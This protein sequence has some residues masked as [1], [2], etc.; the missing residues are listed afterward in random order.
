MQHEELK[1]ILEA[2]L[3]SSEKPISLATLTALF[4]EKGDITPQEIRQA[5]HS[6]AQDYRHRAFELKEVASG[7]CLQTKVQYAAW[8]G[9]LQQE[10]PTKYSRA[11]LE[12]LAIIAYQ[13]PVTRADIE[14]IRGV[15]VSSNL[16]KTLLER[17]WI[18][19][20]GHRD[21]PGKPLLYWTTPVFLNYF[22]L[23]KLT[24]LPPL[25]ACKIPFE[26]LN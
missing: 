1:L 17:G 14:N 15:S 8:I 13:Q 2:L 5:L 22:N 12:T 10:K 11:L 3:V 24:D 18:K 20:A 21:V 9:Q 16:L 19:S 4:D 26:D 6:L 25:G 23:K 7:Y